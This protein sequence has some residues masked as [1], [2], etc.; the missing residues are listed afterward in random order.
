MY[1]PKCHRAPFDFSGTCT[2]T[3]FWDSFTDVDRLSGGAR[4]ECGKA[5]EDE[6]VD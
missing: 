5:G 4:L 1:H 2:M 6:E 3:L